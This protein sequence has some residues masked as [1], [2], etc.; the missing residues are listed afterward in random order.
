MSSGCGAGVISPIFVNYQTA[1][2]T[3]SP[4]GPHIVR[5]G[6]EAA[7]LEAWLR[8]EI[9]V[10]VHLLCLL[11]CFSIARVPQTDTAVSSSEACDFPGED[12]SDEVMTPSRPRTTEDLF[13]AIHRYPKRRPLTLIYFIIPSLQMTSQ[14]LFSFLR[15]LLSLSVTTH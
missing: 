14:F 12:G 4:C 10:T 9:L 15:V 3:T 11:A 1:D 7:C 8:T 13:A 5:N 6:R 2:P